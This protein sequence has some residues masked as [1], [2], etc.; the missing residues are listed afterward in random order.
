MLFKF[1]NLMLEVTR[2]CNMQCAHCMR[3]DAQD[4]K[5]T[6]E[7]ISKLLSS[8]TEIE[9]LTITG[10]EPSLAPEVIGWIVKYIRAKNIK[11]GSF[12]CATNARKYSERFVEHLNDLYVLSENPNNCV[13][14]ISVD[15]FHENQS[16]KAMEQYRSLFYYKAEKEKYFLPK[17]EILSEGRAAQNGLGRFQM[18]AQSNIYEYLL[19]VCRFDVGDRV[20]VNALGDVLL[21]ADMS[22]ESQDKY[23]LGNILSDSLETIMREHFYRIP[24]QYYPDKQHCVFCVHL[25]AERGAVSNQAVDNRLYFATAHKA[26]AAYQN[27]LNNIRITPVDTGEMPIPD[28]L[29]MQFMELAPSDG[30]CTG[31]EIIYNRENETPKRVLLEIFR[32]PIEEEFND[33][34]F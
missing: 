4:V 5:M 12:F 16:K 3:G 26:V 18:P 33:V 21:N 29:D 25:T 8:V 28:D 19:H 9:H 34:L 22:Y 24:K 23:K 13:L 11:L 6:Q 2:Q 32:C 17:G 10:G 27:I 30:R 31:T 1:K 7:V 20:Y 14:T 15:Q